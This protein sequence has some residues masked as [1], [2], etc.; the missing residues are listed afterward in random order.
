MVLNL[1]ICALL[2]VVTMGVYAQT[3]TFDFVLFDDP[4]YVTENIHVRSG[5]TA[6]GA[7]WAFTAQH[8]GNWY[9]LTALSHMLDCQMYG[10]SP[11]G[12]H[13]TSVLLHVAN[14]LVLFGVLR[15][16]TGAVWRSAVVAALFALHPLHVESVAWVAARKDVLS[17]FLG[18]TALAAYVGYARRGGVGRYMLVASLLA[19]GLMAKPM[20]VT[21]PLV[22]VLWDYWPLERLRGHG[23]GGRRDE[24]GQVQPAGGPDRSWSLA[25]LMLEKVP[26]LALSAI[27]SLVAILCQQRAGAM[28]STA[29]IALGARVAN[30]AVSYVRYLGK[31][32]WP[33]S[34]AV[35][36][37]HPNLPGGTPW[38]AWQ[39]TGAGALL[40]ALSA[41]VWASRRG[42]AMTGWLWYLGTLVPVIGLVQVGGQAM[43]DRYTY[44]PLIGVFIVAVW[45]GAEVM[46]VAGR[47]TPFLH[48]LLTAAAVL[49]MAGLLVGA[50]TQARHWRDSTSLSRRAL[51]VAP[52]SAH[53]HTNLG[54]SL[55]TAGKLDEA[56][57]EYRRAVEINPTFAKAHSNLGVA[58]QAQ[59]KL[60]EA[61]AHY[62]LAVQLE[63]GFA[64]AY[65]NLGNV[66][67]AQGHL[68]EAIAYY[69][70]ALDADPD[71]VLAH[72]RLGAALALTGQLDEAIRHY[73]RALAIDPRYVDAHSNLGLALHLQ[74][75]PQQ[76][77]AHYRQALQM[78][79]DL[80]SVHNNL[81]IALQA[82]GELDEAIR[83][84]REALRLTPD[85]ARANNNLGIVLQAQG[86]LD[87]AMD[88]YR[89]ALRIEPDYADAHYN[90]G[91]ALQARGDVDAAIGQYQ[92]V[93]ALQPNYARAHYNLAHAL[94]SRGKAAEAR[95]HFEAAQRAQRK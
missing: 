42:Y 84:Y 44:L 10:L 32:V 78:R 57:A 28:T 76:A 30:A 36:Y 15:I 47:R 2:T 7:A 66:L 88:H 58:L 38:T 63:P 43:A 53:M 12:H 16:S 60:D 20:L 3:L 18:L 22:F 79:P 23:G 81:G 67:Q 61:V 74:G 48:S 59:G 68:D 17:T 91:T 73:R 51:D 52:G 95:A 92:Q 34:L 41:A 9:P 46:G 1:L 64:K 49:A 55:Q 11:A 40:A 93:L 77:I 90:L 94:E 25:Q 35:F 87:L 69:R 26:F 8:G 80:A 86:Q 13:L 82:T 5:L 72:E 71:H 75:K 83:H 65:T 54:I 6:A 89:E 45:G 50:R 37:P 85:N 21:L 31:T 29:E 62:R 33:T 14:T 39:V 27:A 70:R 56:I 24:D 4:M 19:L